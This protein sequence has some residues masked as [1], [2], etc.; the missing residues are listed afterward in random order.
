M[1][2]S[3]RAALGVSLGAIVLHWGFQL[4]STRTSSVLPANFADLVFVVG[5][6]KLAMLAALALLLRLQGQGF[7][8]L[9]LHRRDWRAR[10]RAGLFIGAAM[11][12]TLNVVLT[13]FMN[14]LIPPAAANGPSVMAFFTQP[15]NLLAWLPIGI[16]GGGLVEELERIFILTRFEQA[17]GRAGLF[18]A[19]FLS[20]AM[21]GIGHVYQG[22]G[23]AMSTAV[24]GLV[25]ALVY[26]RRRSAVEPIVAHAFSD[27]LAM[28]AATLLAQ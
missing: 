17:F 10:L 2:V 9:G 6:N 8:S 4:A 5:R 22:V 25:F 13:S 23:T 28:L 15:I 12:V 3:K 19:V 21:F 7:D 18:L 24:S 16:V 11:F 14:A 27:V 26:L 1:T 20:S